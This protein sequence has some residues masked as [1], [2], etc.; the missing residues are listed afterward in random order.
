LTW[1][2]RSDEELTLFLKQNGI[3]NCQ[4]TKNEHYVR[5]DT[6]CIAK[7][8]SDLIG[9]IELNTNIFEE[10]NSTNKKPKMR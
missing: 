1:V 4:D 5:M 2:L 3:L 10:T 7:F 9:C 8:V 6:P